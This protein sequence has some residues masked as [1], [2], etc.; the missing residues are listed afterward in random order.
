VISNDF[1]CYLKGACTLMLLRG[2]ISK[3][4]FSL[5]KSDLRFRFYCLLGSVV[6]F[7]IYELIMPS[8][9]CH[10]HDGKSVCVLDKKPE[11]VAHYI[12]LNLPPFF[13]GNFDIM[14]NHATSL[15]WKFC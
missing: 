15:F 3:G 12:I 6:I 10:K 13:N 1:M 11:T 4:K 2:E 8:F 7:S 9:L 14:T 5:R